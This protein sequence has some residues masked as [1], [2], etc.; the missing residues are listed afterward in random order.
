MRLAQRCG[1]GFELARVTREA[2]QHK[3]RRAGTAGVVHHERLT[4]TGQRSHMYSTNGVSAPL[5]SCSFD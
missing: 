2:K 3:D 4:V 1:D 5:R